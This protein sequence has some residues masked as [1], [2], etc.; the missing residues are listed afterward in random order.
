MHHNHA[1][2]AK[3][4]RSQIE[5]VCPD[6]IWSCPLANYEESTWRPALGAGDLA[7]AL[8]ARLSRAARS[9][10]GKPG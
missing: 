7:A 4:G 9:S 3:V 6:G 5:W 8:C 10:F 2:V 1:L